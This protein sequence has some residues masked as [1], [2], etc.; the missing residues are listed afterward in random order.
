MTVDETAPTGQ[1]VGFVTVFLAG[2]AIAT[3]QFVLEVG[4]STRRPEPLPTELRRYRSAFASYARE[5]RDE[6]L[7]VI[8]GLQKIAPQLDV[9][10]DVVSLRAGARWQQELQTAINARD[11]FYLFWSRAARKSEW[12]DRERRYALS[13]R[14]LDFID[15]VPLEPR[16]LLRPP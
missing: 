2:L 5:D 16:N 3:L 4:V 13:A 7:R 11:V 10:L 8:Q 9:F 1:R 14:G 15:P 6:V 12:V